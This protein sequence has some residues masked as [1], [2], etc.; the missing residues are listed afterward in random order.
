MKLKNQMEIYVLENIDSV[1]E[2]YPDCCKCECCRRD[3]AIIALNHLRPKYVS[4]EMGSVYTKLD[5]TLMENAVEIIEEIAKAIE[6]V[7]KN[8]RH[9]GKK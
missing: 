1:L 6:I 9:E 2:K 3:I 5:A 7:Q 8:P 4:S